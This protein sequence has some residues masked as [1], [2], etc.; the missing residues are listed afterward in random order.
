MVESSANILPEDVMIE[1]LEVGHDVCKQIIEMQEELV[2]K[3]DVEKEVFVEKEEPELNKTISEKYLDEAKTAAS[4]PGKFERRDAL[5]ALSA[6]LVETYADDDDDAKPSTGEVKSAFSALQTKAI[7]TCILENKRIDGRTTTEVRP[8]EIETAFLP[9]THG[10]ALFTR[11]E[12]QAMV[13]TTLGTE[14]DA[15]LVEGM[16]EMTTETFLLHYNFPGFSVGESKPPRGPGRREIGHGKLAWK[17]LKPV[18]PNKNEFPY[19][20]RILSDITES[21]G[22]SSMATV[23]GGAMSMLDAGVPL[24]STVAGIA[25]G[26]VKEGDEYVVLTD[27]LGD[28]DHYGDMDFKVTGTS[29][30]ITALQM[31]IKIDGL[32]SDV[33]AR[34]L[35]QAR[36]GRL[37]ILDVMNSVLP[38][39]REDVSKFAPRIIQIQIDKEKIGKLIGP[40][41]K[42]INGLQEGTGAKIEVN[43][44]GVVTVSSTNLEKVV[45]AQAAIEGL[46]VGPRVGTDFDGVVKSIRDFGAFV[47][48]L[49][50]VEALVHVSELDLGYVKN[51]NDVCKEGENMRVRVIKVDDQGRIKCSRKVILAEEKGDSEE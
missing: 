11:G 3:L 8:I 18:L 17:A 28:E 12:T 19:T 46:F 22:S 39:A 43:D 31:D 48:I 7:R 34:A 23:C 42:T 5:K 13:S 6:K 16:F 38:A 26:L 2:A 51:P 36:E 15:Q 32:P 33:M 21:N 10:S 50:G 20:L 30:G 25:M 37:K 40:G 4:T 45:A 14:D 24:K 9:R 29:E 1:G 27:I 44:D 49:P 47:E 41:G 35:G